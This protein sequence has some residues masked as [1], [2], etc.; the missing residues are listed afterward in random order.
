MTILGFIGLI[1]LSIFVGWVQGTQPSGKEILEVLGTALIVIV[2]I[3]LGL[4]YLMT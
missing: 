2:L 4:V 1:A 3:Y